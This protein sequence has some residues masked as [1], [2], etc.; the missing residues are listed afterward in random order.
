[1]VLCFT[2]PVDLDDF[3][4]ARFQKYEHR[5]RACPTRSYRVLLKARGIPRTVWSTSSSGS[6]WKSARFCENVQNL[7][8]TPAYATSCFSSP[9][10]RGSTC[11]LGL[12]WP[13][14]WALYYSRRHALLPVRNCTVDV[15]CAI[16]YCTVHGVV[17]FCTVLYYTG[18]CVVLYCKWYCV[19]CTLLYRTALGSVL[20]CSSVQDTTGYYCIL[21]CWHCPVL[22]CTY[23]N[24]ML[25][26]IALFCTA[27][28]AVLYYTVQYRVL[29]CRGGHLRRH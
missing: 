20:Y 9:T 28:G 1:M 16:L 18:F 13:K 10:A 6:R 19:Y 22:H 4:S 25:F 15:H 26:W 17:Q 27:Q 21:H 8:N 12:I 11:F 23:T 2:E 5:A 14:L 7:K 3:K 29:C 24:I